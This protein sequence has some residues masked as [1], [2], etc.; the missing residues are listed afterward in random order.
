MKKIIVVCL[1]LLLSVGLF[2]AGQKDTAGN[3]VQEPLFTVIDSDQREVH[4][5]RSVEK[6]VSLNS[7][8]SSLI[9]ALGEED[10]IIGRDMFSTFPSSLRSVFVVG[11]NS[12]HPNMELILSLKPDLV[13]ADRM[14]D[15]GLRE[16]LQS[17]QIPV[18]IES[19][20]DPS[21]VPG[22]IQRYGEI[23]DCSERAGEIINYLKI[24]E[25]EVVSRVETAQ[26]NSLSA[27]VVFFENRKNYK[28]ASRKSSSHQYITLSGGINLAA[29][30]SVTS[31]TLSPEFIVHQ[32]PEIII[33]RVSGD[34]TKETMSGLRNN[35]LNRPGISVTTAVTTGQV[36]II[37]ADLFLTVRYPSALCYYGAWF[38]PEAFK[39]LTPEDFHRNLIQFL[40]GPEE[41]D[42]THETFVFP[43]N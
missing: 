6:I 9:A 30:E 3:T 4:F 28:S 21:K 39:D 15:K 24:A 40:Y 33:R 5:Y 20:S 31:P 11:K 17:L 32:N 1:F 19:T 18:L 43:G 22:L 41:W 35:I 42:K 25:S 8:M 7:G 12:A 13:V 26:R 37:K 14:F 10:R 34:I 16:K 36:Y 2:A 27:P 29:D 23:L 38:F